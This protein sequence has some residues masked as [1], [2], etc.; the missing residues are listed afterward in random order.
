MKVNRFYILFYI[1]GN[2]IIII[3]LV[4]HKIRN[5]FQ[6][7]F[8]ISLP[9]LLHLLP[10]KT[11]ITMVFGKPFKCPRIESPTAQQEAEVLEQYIVALRE[12]WNKYK[13]VYATDRKEE[14]TII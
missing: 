9:L 2:K 14:L 10:K 8:G 13:D 6:R 7:I 4:V 11:K 12:L 1:F 3:I 5:K